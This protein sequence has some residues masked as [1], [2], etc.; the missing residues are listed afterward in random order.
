MEEDSVILGAP[1]GALKT[2]ETMRI[3]RNHNLSQPEAVRRIDTFLDELVQRPLP[4][5]LHLTAPS[6]SWSGDLMS[7]SFKI[8]KGWLGAT[9]AGTFRVTDQSVVFDSDLPGLVTLFAPEEDI[10]N[11]INQQ[12]DGLLGGQY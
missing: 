10:R 1:P 8:N 7:F 3:E 6:K 9:I 11:V 5:G 4:A 12:L 2:G